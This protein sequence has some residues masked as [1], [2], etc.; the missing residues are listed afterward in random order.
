M[1]NPSI[2]RFQFAKMLTQ[3]VKESHNINYV[4]NNYSFSTSS[5]LT[6]P[7]DDKECVKRSGTHD[8]FALYCACTTDLCNTAPN[9]NF[10]KLISAIMILV[11][12]LIPKLL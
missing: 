12:T 6:D 9:L 4:N 11:L 5:Y 1:D 2:V 3:G 8:V 10:N 7:R